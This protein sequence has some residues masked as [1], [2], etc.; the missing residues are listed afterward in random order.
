MERPST[1]GLPSSP[2]TLEGMESVTPPEP[3]PAPVPEAELPAPTRDPD[4]VALE[5]F[6]SEFAE[7]EVELESVE[8]RGGPAAGGGAVTPAS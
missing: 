8:R 4:L 2:R 6:E 1:S 3:N 5:G 7:L